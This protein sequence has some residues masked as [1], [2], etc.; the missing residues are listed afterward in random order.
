MAHR[1]S[2]SLIAPALLLAV[3]A[4]AGAALAQHATPSEEAAL[5]AYREGSFSR[6]VQL[7]T[8][9]LSESDEP[10]HR[11]QLHVSIAW[12]L[13]AL[14]RQGEVDTHLRAALVEDP[15]LSLTPDYYTKEFIELFDSTKARVRSAAL[16]SSAAPPPDLEATLAAVAARLESGRD[17]EGALADVEKLLV[18]YPGDGRLLPLRAELL[19]L[20]GRD[21]EA[22]TILQAYGSGALQVPVDSLSI[23]DLILR[24]NRLLDE[25]D[26]EA[27][28]G[29][30]R[31]AVS[32]QPSNVAALELMAEAA[33]RTGRWQDAEF[34]LKSALGLQPDNLNLQ[35]RLGGVYLAKNDTSAARDVFRE[36]TERYP[37]SDRAWASLGL[38]DAQLGNHERALLELEQALRENPLLPEV[39]L[40]YGELL[41]TQGRAAEALAAFQAA[42]NLLPDDP[43]LE[44]RTGQ[45]LLAAGRSGDV[46]AHLRAAIDGGFRPFDV[47]RSWVLNLIG[48]GDHAEAA[49]ALADIPADPR[50]DRDIVQGVLL[51]EQ[52]AFAES[53]AVL[54]RAAELRASDAAL[55]NLLAAAIY[56]QQRYGEAVEILRRAVDLQPA[57]EAIVRNLERAEAARAAELLADRA[58]PVKPAGES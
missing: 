10:G 19:R 36:L 44:A 46:G 3:L 43:Q 32:R 11:A 26:A 34:A 14:G 5:Q 30:L 50:R 35:L 9:A 57:N 55:L 8:R 17:L 12:T 29:L 20:L 21:D 6:A 39:Q 40:G 54:R 37:H 7:Y 38:L 42:K 4:A 13:F 2:A 49:R 33:V 24:A 48:N 22:Q 15:E 28:F 16:D 45:A 51:L 1:A 31:E 23:P 53:E 41:L 58:E 52:G 25:G 47:Q 27:A 18:A 56:E